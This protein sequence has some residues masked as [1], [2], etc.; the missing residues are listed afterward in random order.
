M[1]SRWKA[2]P[3]FFSFSVFYYF[4][5]SSLPFFFSSNSFFFWRNI[6]RTPSPISAITMVRHYTR[7]QPTTPSP[8]YRLSMLVAAVRPPMFFYSFLTSPGWRKILYHYFP[9]FGLSTD[10]APTWIVGHNGLCCFSNGLPKL[11]LTTHLDDLPRLPPTSLRDTPPKSGLYSIFFAKYFIYSSVFLF[12]TFSLFFFLTCGIKTIYISQQYFSIFLY[13]SGWARRWRPN[14]FRSG[15]PVMI[16]NMCIKKKSD[17]KRFFYL[18]C[19]WCPYFV[20]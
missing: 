15:L 18:N 3:L 16:K 9:L 20:Y 10:T 14:E 17:T 12:P 6:P 11:L 1:W 2:F 13:L 5:C 19:Y 8:T 4:F 7:S